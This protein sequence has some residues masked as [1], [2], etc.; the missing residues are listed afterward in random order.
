MIRLNQKG[1][2]FEDRISFSAWKLRRFC[3]FDWVY[4]E[5]F[6]T[7]ENCY[8]KFT[9][10]KLRPKSLAFPIGSE[11]TDLFSSSVSNSLW[12]TILIRRGKWGKKE[13]NLPPLLNRQKKDVTVT[14]SLFTCR[15]AAVLRHYLN[16]QKFSQS[17]PLRRT[18][19]RSNFKIYNVL[20]IWKKKENASSGN[21]KYL[22]SEL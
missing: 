22:S 16:T 19:Q 10:I 12:L 8:L 17:Y 13:Q 4:S 18:N 7:L 5:I 2:S 6:W 3:R 15:F 9:P 20:S 11:P 1:K 21:V 14:E